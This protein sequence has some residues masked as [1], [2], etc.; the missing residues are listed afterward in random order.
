[1]RRAT[2]AAPGEVRLEDGV[3]VPEPGPQEIRVRS[4]SVGICGSDLHALAGHHPF[5]DL[6]VVPGHEAAGV[7]DA[8]GAEVTGFAVGERVLLEPN[9]IDGTCLYCRTGR[10]NLC[11]HLVVVGCTTSGALA[12]A[13]VAPAGRFHLVP[14]GMSMTE[15]AMVEPLSTATHAVRVA[16]GLEGKTVAVLG[17]GTIGLLTLL[18]ARASGAVAA[19]VTDPIDAKRALALELGADLAVD[20]TQPGAVERIRDGLPWRP[21][22]VF[23]CVSSQA[24]TDQAIALA[25]KGG[26]VVVEGVPRGDVRVPLPLIQDR[27]LRLQG[28]AMYTREDVERAIGLIEGAVVPAARLVTAEFPLERAAEA[29]QAAADGTEIKVHLRL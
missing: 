4:H 3:A 8:V 16:G 11:E 20:P 13:F 14:D 26:T 6:P 25:L 7:V 18:T 24:S 21:D 27:E 22:V 28:T 29:F 17:A 15:A 1:M 2:L 23:D 19:A 12:D 10:Y 9:L 5:I